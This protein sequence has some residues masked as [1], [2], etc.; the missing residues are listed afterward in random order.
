M[1]MKNHTHIKEMQTARSSG[2]IRTNLSALTEK[3]NQA[4]DQ[5]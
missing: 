2:R 3:S 4:S 1:N 5:L